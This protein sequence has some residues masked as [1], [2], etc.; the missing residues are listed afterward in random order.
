VATAKTSVEYDT[1]KLEHV[2]AVLGTTTFEDSI[3]TAWD[4]VLGLATQLTL[5]ESPIDSPVDH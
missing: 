4:V 1:D 3:D 2:K 5:I